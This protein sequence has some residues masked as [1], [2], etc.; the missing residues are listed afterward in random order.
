MFDLAIQN[1]YVIDPS[2]RIYSRLNVG[3]K[4]GRI[5]AVTSDEISGRV[6]IDAAG[7]VVSPGFI[8]MHMH[9]DPYDE[10]KGSFQFL[11]SHSMLKM[12]VTTVVGGNCG[13]GTMKNPVDYLNA[14]DRLG[15]PV[16]I[17]MLS[18]HEKLRAAFCDFSR[19]EPADQFD[20]DRMSELL[21]IHLDGGCLGLSL[22]MEY[23]PGVNK[24]EA[25]ALMRVA[26]K[27]HKIVTV[28]QRSDGDRA[29]SSVEEVIAYAAETGVKLQISH[30]SSMCSFGSMDEAISIIDSSRSKGLD[31]LFDGYPYYAFCT[32]IGSAVFDEGFL[33][34]YDYGDEYYARLQ[35]DPGYLQGK[36]MNKNA[37]RALREKDPGALVVAHLLNGEEVD[38]CITHPAS[39]VVS[40]GLY[41]NGQGHPRGSGTFPR[42]IREYVIEKKLLTLEDAI[43]KITCMPAKRMGLSGKGSLKIGSDA[44]ITIFDLNK[45]KDGA[46]YQEPLKQPEGIEYVVINGEIAL[47]SGEIVKNC[48]GKSVRM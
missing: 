12:G 28:H 35:V 25:T 5:A 40:D 2:A 38:R 18:P 46:T 30:L 10:E 3:V 17:G 33:K 42:L 19:Y 34:K 45:I 27:N 39:V 6:E 8:D 47:K 32:A 4:N 48:L 13:I 24:A 26:E 16:N 1:G 7:F 22:G 20:I 15:Y 37:F 14:V 21:Q 44:D 9:E 41:N 31:V 36:E 29:L 11:I 23:I 43:E